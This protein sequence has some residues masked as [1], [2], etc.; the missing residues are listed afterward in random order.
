MEHCFGW[1]LLVKIR[2]SPSPIRR[3]ERRVKWRDT[4]CPP[5]I[6]VCWLNKGGEWQKINWLRLQFR[7]CPWIV[8]EWPTDGFFVYESLPRVSLTLALGCLGLTPRGPR[9]CLSLSGTMAV[10]FILTCANPHNRCN[11]MHWKAFGSSNCV[12]VCVN[13]RKLKNVWTYTK[14][15]NL[16][17]HYKQLFCKLIW[18]STLLMIDSFQREWL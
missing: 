2:P 11:W 17:G 18:D 5:F 8:G 7:G 15:Q 1:S 13:C 16:Y 10:F 3:D 14:Y 4:V 12:C 9:W 6:F